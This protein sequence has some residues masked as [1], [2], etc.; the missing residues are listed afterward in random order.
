MYEWTPTFVED[1]HDIYSSDDE[2]EDNIG[3]DFAGDK[4]KIDSSDID[5]FSESSF[6]HAI[7]LVHD[8]SNNNVA[9]DVGSH[10]EYPFNL[11]GILNNHHKKASNSS[12]V[13][14]EYPLDLH[15]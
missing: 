7:D 4:D 10:S 1:N 11:Y 8:N 14:P 15:R 6:S 9:R 12:N 3:G 2:P 13:E 5:R